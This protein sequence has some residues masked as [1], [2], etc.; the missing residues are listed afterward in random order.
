M[1]KPDSVR[2]IHTETYFALVRQSL[3][4]T[5]WAYVR[6]TGNSMMPL[7]RH[8]RDGV[9]LVPPK[10][11]RLGD[12]VLFDR[13][14][15]R[16]ALHRVVFKGKNSFVMAGDYQWYLDRNLPYSQIVGVVDALDR[17]GHRISRGNFFTKMYSWLVT[18]LTLPRI[19][20]W[21]RVKILAR[22]FRHLRLNPGKERTDEN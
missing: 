4:D 15:G 10:R 12:I 7:L 11:V 3:A 6:V 21:K 19:Y 18:A 9:I 20:L 13:M 2:I 16:Y 22:P 1:S 14:N 17:K 8:M 5:G